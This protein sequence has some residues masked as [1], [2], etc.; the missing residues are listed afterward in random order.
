MAMFLATLK[1]ATK[2]NNL[3][4]TVIFYHWSEDL[5]GLCEIIN[6]SDFIVVDEYYNERPSGHTT[7]VVVFN[8]Q[9]ILNTSDIAKCNLIKDQ[10]KAT[11]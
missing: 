11:P 1:V 6:G 9:I 5:E 10:P 2:D 7:P 8:K 3:V 4:H